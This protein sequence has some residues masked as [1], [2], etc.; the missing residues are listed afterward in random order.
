MK[1]LSN[2][3]INKLLINWNQ[4]IKGKMKRQEV[5]REKNLK[6]KN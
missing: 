6:G 4:K 3:K 2:I 1:I 5:K